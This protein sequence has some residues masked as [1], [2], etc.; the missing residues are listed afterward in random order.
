M[1]NKITT[2]TSEQL[3]KRATRLPGRFV[4]RRFTQDAAFTYRMGAGFPGTVTRTHP[5]SIWPGQNDPTNP[6]TAW[7]QALLINSSANTW[8][9]VLTS[10]DAI[11]A[12]QGI[13]V[14]PFP[15]QEGSGSDYGAQ[16]FGTGGPVVPGQPLDILKSG[17]I[18]VLVNGTPA[19]GGPVYLWV[20]AA[21]G[22]HIVGG[23]E[24]AASSGN[25]VELTADGQTYFNGPPDASGFAELCFNV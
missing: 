12:I 18:I 25:T 22:S 5:A 3:I 2:L 16:E 17:S 8:R 13:L 10:D 11:D 23:F 24:A 7:G 9:S 15:V 6:A 20:A 14:R 4:G 21:T 1:D 19:L